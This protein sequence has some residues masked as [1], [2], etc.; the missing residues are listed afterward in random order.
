VHRHMRTDEPLAVRR[1]PDDFNLSRIQGKEP[2][3]IPE[4]E[5][6]WAW[7]GMASWGLIDDTFD[8]TAQIDRDLEREAH[9]LAA[10]R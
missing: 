3:S 5:A 1:L 8:V 6:R 2:G 7:A 10:I 4:H 9:E